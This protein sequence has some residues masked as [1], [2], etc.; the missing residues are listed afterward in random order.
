MGQKYQAFY[1]DSYR[2]FM[3]TLAATIANVTADNNR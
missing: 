1:K 3:T 2:P